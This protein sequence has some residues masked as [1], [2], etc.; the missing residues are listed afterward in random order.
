[1]P[2]KYE[3][4]EG[5]KFHRL[6]L[7]KGKKQNEHYVYECVC[8]CG[9]LLTVYAHNLNDSSQRKTKSCGCL[10]KESAKKNLTTHGYCSNGIIAKEYDSW[11]LMK[12]RCQ[13]KNCNKYPSYGGRGIT[14]CQEW[15]DFE[16]FIKDMGECPT[17][18]TLERIDNNGNYEKA[19]CKWASRS[20][21][22]V[23]K[24]KLERNKTGVV[25]VHLLKSGKY[26]ASLNYE[27]KKYSLGVF[28]T[29]EEAKKVRQ[30]AELKHFGR[31]LH[32][33]V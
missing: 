30:E 6:T 8:D 17:G 18:F 19:N 2:S 3:G 5:T 20:D 16:N 4:L 32:Q 9:N 25:G 12:Q 1:M 23:N 24:R 11:H 22:Q 26:G 28:K 15:D 13:N 29:L 31:I 7:L 21:Q 10:Q 33:E 14:V 27:N